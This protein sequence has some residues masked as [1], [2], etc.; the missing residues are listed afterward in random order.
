MRRQVER[1]LPFKPARARED[2]PIRPHPVIQRFHRRG[3][4]PRAHRASLCAAQT[5][6]VFPIEPLQKT[7]SWVNVNPG[8]LTPSPLLLTFTFTVGRSGAVTSAGRR[9]AYCENTSLYSRVTRKSLPLASC[10]HTC[11]SFMSLTATSDG[12]STPDYWS[13]L[14][15]SI[16]PAVPVEGTQMPRLGAFAQN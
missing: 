14:A 12:I 7:P 11:P 1:P 8:K 15:T 4:E 13:P 10:R 5:A 6:Q 9:M 2:H 16:V 3:E